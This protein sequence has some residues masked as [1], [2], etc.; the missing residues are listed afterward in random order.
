[1]LLRPQIFKFCVKAHQSNLDVLYEMSK[2]AKTPFF[3]IQSHHIE[4]IN[5]PL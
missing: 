5:D 1:M 3:T 2:K 4:I